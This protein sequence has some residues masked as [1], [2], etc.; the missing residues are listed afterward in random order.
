MYASS[1][2]DLDGDGDDDVGYSATKANIATVFN[3]LQTTL[4]TGDHLFIFTTDHG[5]PEAEPHD[6]MNV[7]LNLWGETITDNEFT[8]EV[9]KISSTVPIMIT[10]EQCFSGGF[11]DDIIPAGFSGQDRVIATAANASEFSYGDTF[12]TLWI[13]AVAGHDKSGTAVDADVD[14]NGK[15]SMQ[16]AFNYAKDNDDRAE[17]PQF[18]ET[19]AGIGSSL[20]LCSCYAPT[21]PI[22]AA[23]MDQTVEQAALA[24]TSVTLD[25]SGS[26]D[27]CGSGLTYAWTWPGGSA[28]K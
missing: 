13:S 27:P 7:V 9:D 3:D 12:S 19:P 22:A 14:D 8:A 4:G 17:H 2:P 18:G 24:G 10:M 21:P 11:I 25:G 5:G 15:V 20:A 26:S 1:D 16:E 23:G 28:L 6:D